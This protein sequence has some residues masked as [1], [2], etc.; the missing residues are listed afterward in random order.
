M[1]RSAWLRLTLAGM[2]ATSMLA[3]G[4]CSEPQAAAPKAE[5]APSGVPIPP[6]SGGTYESHRQQSAPGGSGAPM[7]PGMPGGNGPGR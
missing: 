3:L 2:V 4:G 5:T 1:I 6:G 7:P